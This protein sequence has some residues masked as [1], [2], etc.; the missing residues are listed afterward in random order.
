MK[1][2]Y[3]LNYWI[4]LFGVFFLTTTTTTKAEADLQVKFGYVDGG[5]IIGLIKKIQGTVIRSKNLIKSPTGLLIHW[6][7]M[8][9]ADPDKKRQLFKILELNKNFT[10]EIIEL[11]SKKPG[12]ASGTLKWANQKMKFNAEYGF[13]GGNN[14]VS[15]IFHLNLEKFKFNNLNLND[16]DLDPIIDLILTVPYNNTN[17][18]N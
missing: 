15:M 13:M 11:D 12:V 1:N 10:M 4:F 7:Q 5:G 16:Q 9:I 14:E 6:D 2:R 17:S 3:Y 8:Q 18:N